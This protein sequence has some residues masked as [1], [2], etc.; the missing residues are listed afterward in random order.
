MLFRSDEIGEI[1]DYVQDQAGMSADIIWG[2]CIDETLDERMSVTIIATGFKTRDELDTEVV[3]RE[4]NSPK[5]HRLDLESPVVE[6]VKHEQPV[7]NKVELTEP[8]LVSPDAKAV[9]QPEA[10]QQF[11]FEFT[12]NGSDETAEAEFDEAMEMELRREPMEEKEQITIPVIEDDQFAKSRERLARLRA[13]NSRLGGPQL[14]ELER[15]PAYKR[16]N[17]KLESGPHSSDSNLSR[18]TL[19]N[20]EDKKT[21]IQI[22]RAHV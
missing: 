6:T 15:E 8:V 17:I 19:S 20:E 1:T 13:M 10:S 7:L 11:T 12:V 9:E 18:Y 14:S 16:K 3:D 21:Q 22:G 5:V 2:N 4:K